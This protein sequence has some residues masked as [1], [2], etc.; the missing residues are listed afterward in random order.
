MTIGQKILLLEI[1]LD[2]GIALHQRV[3]ILVRI[4]IYQ[5]HIRRER[6]MSVIEELKLRIKEETKNHMFS[7]DT[8]V[9]WVYKNVLKI[10]EE[11][12]AWEKNNVK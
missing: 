10:I 6:I 7:I 11:L 12:E 5:Q 2:L 9:P 8:S 3:I 4:F 1:A